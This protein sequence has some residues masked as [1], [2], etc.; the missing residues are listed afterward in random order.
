MIGDLISA[1]LNFV[2]GMMNRSA[3]E[4]A[5]AQNMALQREFAQKNLDQQREFAQQ[6]VRWKVED[7]KAAGLH[8]LAALGANTSS[9]SPITVGSDTVKAPTL[10]M[11]SMGQDIGRAVNAATTSEEKADAYTAKLKTLQLERGELENS[12]LKTQIMR[13]NQP[14][15][16]QPSM[17]SAKPSTGQPVLDSIE[18]TTASGF[19]VTQDKVEQK[20]DLIPAT[21]RIPMLGGSLHTWK[22]SPDAEDVE[23]RYGDLAEKLGV[24][25]I[26]LDVAYTIWKNYIEHRVPTT[27]QDRWPGAA[28]SLE[29]KHLQKGR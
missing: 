13:A 1:G 27:F 12:L 15:G 4:E 19:P 16:R 3:Q 17:P 9:F 26:P 6:G 28:R 8:P 14:A 24:A 23:T 29:S 21:K 7:A 10:D 22:G 2:G 20:P 5:N 25:N 11:G 18:P